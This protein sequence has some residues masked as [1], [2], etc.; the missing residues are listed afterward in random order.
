[1]RSIEIKWRRWFPIFWRVSSSHK[2]R[3]MLGKLIREVR[4]WI[5][6]WLDWNLDAGFYAYDRTSQNQ[7]KDCNTI[8]FWV[9]NIATNPQRNSGSLGEAYQKI[10]ASTLRNLKWA[11][12]SFQKSF[13]S[14]W[15]NL[16]EATSRGWG[17]RSTDAQ[18]YWCPTRSCSLLNWRRALLW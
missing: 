10:L 5:P 1:M 14:K 2:N 18:I 11:A 15:G 8:Y 16:L 17:V 3:R 12:K 4:F 7:G 9:E 6:L 13:R